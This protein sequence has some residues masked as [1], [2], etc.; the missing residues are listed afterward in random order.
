M[1][2][3]KNL[4]EEFDWH[5]VGE[6]ENDLK[7]KYFDDV[8]LELDAAPNLILICTYYGFNLNWKS[9]HNQQIMKYINN[10]LMTLKIISL[11]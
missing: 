8:N 4:S 6:T 3:I 7:L 10:I 1:F 9:S 2:K 5:S 11:D